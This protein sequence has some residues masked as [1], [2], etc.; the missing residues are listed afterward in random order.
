MAAASE[1]S[2]RRPRKAIRLP[3]LADRALEAGELHA[4]GPAP[5]GP[6]V[7]HHRM[8]AQLREPLLEG[9]GAAGQQLIGL[10]VELGQRLRRARQRLRVVGR[11]GRRGRRRS[12]CRTPA[13]AS[14]TSRKCRRRGQASQ[15]SNRL[16]LPVKTRFRRIPF[17]TMV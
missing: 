15:A 16:I 1:S 5:R 8:A 17:S 7:D 9:V 2:S 10:V 13:G 6:L 3:R 14:A 12:R 11:L 4:A